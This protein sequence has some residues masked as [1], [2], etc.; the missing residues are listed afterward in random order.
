MVVNALHHDQS[1]VI[2][3]AI[4]R[5]TR[6]RTLQAVEVGL[7]LA[8]QRFAGFFYKVNVMPPLHTA[9]DLG[10]NQQANRDRKKMNEKLS[11]SAQRF[12]RCMNFQHGLNPRDDLENAS[13]KK[14]A[15]HTLYHSTE[16]SYSVG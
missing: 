10:R 3:F 13:Q 8:A 1:R 5:Q 2:I 12:M 6:L 11:N 16:R 4:L 9:L 14:N 7:N 15:M